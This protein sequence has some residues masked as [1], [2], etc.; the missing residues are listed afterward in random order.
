M[1]TKACNVC[2]R[3]LALAHFHK[4]RTRSDG[5]RCT[6]KDCVRSYHSTPERR[7]GNALLAR[8]TKAR[9]KVSLEGKLCSHCGGSFQPRIKTQRF[10]AYRCQ[11]LSANVRERPNQKLR[12]KKLRENRQ[13]IVC[14]E[15]LDVLSTIV[16]CP[17]CNDK[18][19][20]RA[21]MWYRELRQKVIAL[22]GGKCTCCGEAEIDFLALDHVNNDGSKQR[23][24]IGTGSSTYRFV[25]KNRPTDIQ[26]LCHNCNCAKAFYGV[27]PHE[28]LRLNEAGGLRIRDV[29]PRRFACE[30][31]NG[32]A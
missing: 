19:R 25:L 23:K 4:D 2:G 8:Q 14:T 30:A 31:I 3:V 27:C 6:C 29:G 10:C 7:A 20:V 32:Q 16:R 1:T 5:L 9:R 13:C 21:R 12:V 18:A 28:R 24:N 26:I 22:Y 15:R 17:P 11:Q